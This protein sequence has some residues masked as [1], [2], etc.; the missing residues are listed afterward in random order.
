MREDEEKELDATSIIKDSTCVGL[1]RASIISESDHDLNPSAC[2]EFL[3]FETFNE[4]KL[5]AKV[6]FGV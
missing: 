1:F 2:K 6:C 3:G 4:T 5:H